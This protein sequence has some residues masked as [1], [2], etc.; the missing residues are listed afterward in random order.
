M[1]KFSVY[2]TKFKSSSLSLRLNEK[3]IEQG[4]ALASYSSE[5]AYRL[6]VAY[7]NLIYVKPDLKNEKFAAFKKEILENHQ[8]SRFTD[9]FKDI[10]EI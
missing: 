8:E 10:D 7:G 2:I 9:V 4:I 1:L 5:A 6:S 3:I